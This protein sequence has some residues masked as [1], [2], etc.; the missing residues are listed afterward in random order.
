MAGKM[1]HW[2]C[3]FRNF[4]EPLGT[5]RNILVQERVFLLGRLPLFPLP[6]N[7]SMI[8]ATLPEWIIDDICEFYIFLMRYKAPIFENDSRDEF[9]TFSMVMLSNSSYIKNPYLKS[10]LVEILFTFTLPL[11][12]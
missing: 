8:F 1:W 2:C 11:W 5:G 3:I 6:T 7:Q 4:M 9:I 10:K 12:R